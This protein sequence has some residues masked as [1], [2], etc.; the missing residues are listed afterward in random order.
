LSRF[1]VI[2]LVQ[3][4]EPKLLYVCEMIKIFKIA[5]SLYEVDYET[6][7]M[8]MEIRFA[9]KGDLYRIAEM[10][11]ALT[12]HL[13]AFEWSVENHLKHVKRRFANTRYVHIVAEQNNSIIGF[14]GA[15][16]KTKRTAYVLKGYVEPS[17]RR[18]GVMRKLES[19]L[20]DSLREK[21]VSKIDLKVDSSNQ[22][23]KT[24]WVALGYKT[25]R[26]NMRKQI[27]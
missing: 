4:F 6:G 14:T 17:Y 21:G 11:R 5:G 12:L 2:A 25:I 3:V 15:E 24:T 13:G 27:K 26:E 22:E 9:T 10:T 19:K 7:G 18:K 16:L 20:I 8:S 23:G 1:F